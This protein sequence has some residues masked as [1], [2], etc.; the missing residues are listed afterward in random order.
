MLRTGTRLLAGIALASGLTLGATAVMAQQQETQPQAAPPTEA[1]KIDEQ[2]LETYAKAAA[3]VQ[4]INDSYLPKLKQAE[5]ANKIDAIRKEAE[6]KMVKAI[7]DEGL[8]VEKY[9]RITIALRNDPQLAKEVTKMIKDA[10]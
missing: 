3:K 10:Q 8:T 5:D 7:S 9:N 4:Q 1:Q 6:S 2:Q